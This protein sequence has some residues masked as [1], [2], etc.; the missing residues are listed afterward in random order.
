M[1]HLRGPMKNVVILCSKPVEICDL[2]GKCQKCDTPY[3]GTK[4][5]ISMKTVYEK[6]CDFMFKAR[7]NLRFKR[8]TSILWHPLSRNKMA[9]FNENGWWLMWRKILETLLSGQ[10]LVVF[11]SKK[12]TQSD[13]PIPKIGHFPD[14][15]TLCWGLSKPKINV[16]EN[17]THPFSGRKLSI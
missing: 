7:E 5:P 10:I 11:G 14:P 8:K 4:W 6:C 12:V 13:R 15:S 17:E 2:R 1:N 16:T 3:P 9:D